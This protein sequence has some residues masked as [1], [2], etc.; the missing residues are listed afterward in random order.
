[1][2]DFSVCSQEQCRLLFYSPVFIYLRQIYE[3]NENLY[4]FQPA[5]EG[6]SQQ[7]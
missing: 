5:F 3:Y 7:E 4:F 1:M 2:Y 6:E